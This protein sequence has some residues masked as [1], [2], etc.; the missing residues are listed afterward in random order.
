MTISQLARCCTFALLPMVAWAGP[1]T[2]S[3]DLLMRDWAGNTVA[4]VTQVCTS[5]NCALTQTIP[6]PIAPVAEAEVTNGVLRGR[7]RIA[8]DY[9]E[10]GVRVG[11]ASL[12]TKA[13]FE[14][15][16][17]V[18][19]TLEGLQSLSL[20]EDDLSFLTPMASVRNGI[21]TLRIADVTMFNSQVSDPRRIVPTP[22]TTVIVTDSHNV[23]TAA[24][25]SGFSEET[26]PQRVKTR[27][28]VGF[29]ND[30]GVDVE[31][32][33]NTAVVDSGIGG[34]G[35]VAFI[36][37]ELTESQATSMDFVETFGLFWQYESL[38]DLEVYGHNHLHVAENDFSHTVGFSG[39]YF[40]DSLGIDI[41]QYFYVQ[42]DEPMTFIGESQSVPEPA[43]WALLVAG[44][45]CLASAGRSKPRADN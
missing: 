23:A 39:V 3:H 32:Q 24:A 36:Q 34:G 31:E 12:K 16:A 28:V 33:I 20:S 40:Y 35:E 27:S 18:Y 38:L 19:Y 26:L 37:Q 6:Y 21:R 4:D 1:V 29:I 13:R 43:T 41:S 15:R 30:Q 45:C 9:A 11:T 8:V 5:P 10:T 2:I 25:T 44:L 42:Y 7:N 17:H 14:N 22:T